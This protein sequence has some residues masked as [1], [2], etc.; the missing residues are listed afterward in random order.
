[1]SDES[2]LQYQSIVCSDTHKHGQLF[3][4][5]ALYRYL[6][7]ARHLS[8]LDRQLGGALAVGLIRGSSCLGCHGKGNVSGCGKH[9]PSPIP[10]SLFHR[11][12]SHLML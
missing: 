2:P 10:L 5:H 8:F 7:S 1:M 4:P 11:L 9:L 3:A 6:R 12:F